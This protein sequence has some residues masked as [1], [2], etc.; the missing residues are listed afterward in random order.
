MIDGIEDSCR[1]Y[2]RL[3]RCLIF[4][5]VKQ[6]LRWSQGW[7]VP[8]PEKVTDLVSYKVKVNGN[9]SKSF[10]CAR[11]D[12]VLWWIKRK[13]MSW[14]EEWEYAIKLQAPPLCIWLTPFC[15]FGQVDRMQKKFIESLSCMNVFLDGRSI[16]ANRTS[17]SVP[18]QAKGS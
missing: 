3:G 10:F 5:G 1:R 18:I 8:S 11:K 2:W 13:G 12:L 4:F 15:L 17:C 7:K 14:L 16:K 9:L 6:R